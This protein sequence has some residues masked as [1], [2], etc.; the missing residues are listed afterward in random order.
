MFQKK[1]VLGIVGAALLVVGVAGGLVMASQLNASASSYATAPATPSAA[2]SYCQLYLSKLASQLNTT[3]DKIASANQAAMQA[4]ID[5]MV[6]DGK[7]TAD[8]KAKLEQRL[9]NVGKN[10]CAFLAGRFGGAGHFGP[11]GLDGALKNARGAI[12]SAVAS[13]LKLSSASTLE[14]DLAAGQSIS[15]IATA[16]HVSISTVNSAYL[17]AVQT[18]LNQAVSSKLITQAQAT[19]MYTKIQSEVSK[20]RYPLLEGR[21]GM[22]PAPANT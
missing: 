14:S 5:Q 12:E 6:K 7:L 20:G 3:T 18:Q 15:A 16:Q 19:T 8:Q 21:H 11:G 10:P 22:G 1:W 2:D 9:Q 4:V 13:A 17:N